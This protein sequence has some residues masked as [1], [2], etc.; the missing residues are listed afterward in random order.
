MSQNLSAKILGQL[1]LMQNVVINLPDL[2]SI[3][4]FV[5][6]GLQDI[7]GVEKVILLKKKTNPGEKSK[8]IFYFDISINNTCYGEVKII[9]NNREL[10]LPYLAYIQNFVFMLG[11]IIEEKKKQDISK[12]YQE[13]LEK[14]V[15]ESTRELRLEKE[16]LIKSQHRFKDLLS[17]IKLLSFML[18]KDGNIIFCNNFLLNVTGYTYEEIIHKNWFDIFIEPSEKQKIESI[19]NNIIRL[20][21]GAV[22]DENEIL[23][24]NKTF[25]VISWSHTALFDTRGNVTGI[26][27]IGEDITVKKQNEYLLK[28]KN[29]EYEALNEE[30]RQANEELWDAK[31]K[32]ERANQLKTEFLRNMSHEIRTPMNGI[33]GFSDM[34]QEHGI[35]AEKLSYFSKIIKDSSSQLLRIIDD[36]LEISIL[37]TDKVTPLEEEFN[38]NELIMQ[39]FSVFNLKARERNIP[40]YQKKALKDKDSLIITDKTKLLK[41]MN[42]LLE[43]ALKYTDEG[44]IEMGYSV[45]NEDLVL[46]VKDTGIGIANEN[47]VAIFERFTQEEKEV[48]AR[49]GGLGLGLAIARENAHLL[50]GNITLASTKGEGSTFT[51]TLPYKS[52]LKVNAAN[53][54][55]VTVDRIPGNY[56][57]LVAEDEEINY[58]YIEAL[59]QQYNHSGLNLMHARNG[60]EVIEFTLGVNAIDLILMD[61]K[62][63]FVDGYEATRI[64]KS[65]NPGIP[66]I[67]QTAYTSESDQSLA[68]ECGFDAFL[69]KPVNKHKFFELVNKYLN[70]EQ[71]R[72]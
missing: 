55:T 58:L 67:A 69:S 4:S 1:L 54:Q 12:L 25:L 43:N 65:Q 53:Q 14:K 27:S 2:K 17:N 23:T 39:L 13:E 70:L 44:Y 59:F 35:S 68:L 56:N 9:L 45:D 34:L 60:K 22:N 57:I 52:S 71:L 41:I 40:I 16:A 48:S 46:Y 19:F 47:H 3:Y 6:R 28:E 61:I 10:F 37:E 20:K 24:R 29:E 30:L 72:A 32:A 33:V 38:L 66:I 15:E 31:L 42:N 8:E 18:D 62:M 49:S 5:G 21:T 63:P 51:V 7:P 36:I 50:G 26:A 11:V 64:I